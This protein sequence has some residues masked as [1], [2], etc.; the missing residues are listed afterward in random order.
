MIEQ[1]DLD[2][3]AWASFWYSFGAKL[4]SSRSP[5]KLRFS[6]EFLDEFEPLNVVHF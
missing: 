6:S 2:M 4:S 5:L 1:I 3:K